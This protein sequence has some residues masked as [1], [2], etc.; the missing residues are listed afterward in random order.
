MCESQVSGC[1]LVTWNVVK[2]QATPL[3]ESPRWTTGFS[4]R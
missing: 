2:A 3:Q 1:Q 4:V